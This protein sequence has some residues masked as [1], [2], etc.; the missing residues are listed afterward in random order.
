M[1]FLKFVITDFSKTLAQ[2]PATL[3]ERAV[4]LQDTKKVGQGGKYKKV[5]GTLN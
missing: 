1:Y 2:A 4:G 3:A 5:R